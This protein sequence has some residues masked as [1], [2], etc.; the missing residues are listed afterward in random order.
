MLTDNPSAP[1]ILVVEDDKD[2][3]RLIQQ[4]PFSLSAMAAQVRELLDGE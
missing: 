1:V 3:A 2:H 4:K